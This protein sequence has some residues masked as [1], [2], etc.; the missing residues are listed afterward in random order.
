MHRYLVAHIVVLGLPVCLVGS[1]A[2]TA[3]VAVIFNFLSVFISQFRIAASNFFD[4]LI[5][6]FFKKREI[7]N[8]FGQNMKLLTFY[9]SS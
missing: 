1:D 9:D 4:F 6:V 3:M 7:S 5:F 2:E 8:V